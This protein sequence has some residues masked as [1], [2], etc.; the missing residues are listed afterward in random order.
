MFVVSDVEQMFLPQPDD[1]LVNLTDSYDIII[2][3][4]ENLPSYFAKSVTI[5][6][7]FLS[8]LQ[9]ATHIAKHIG[10]RLLIF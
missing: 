7:C 5:D 9:A 4:L 1:L 10:G 2:N 6:N 3:L 8:A